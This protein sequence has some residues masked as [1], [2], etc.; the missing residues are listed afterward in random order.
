MVENL[1]V[2]SW[3]RLLLCDLAA[4]PA[5]RPL[6]LSVPDALF[7]Q[8]LWRERVCTFAF[9]ALHV[10]A[11]FVVRNSAAALYAAGCTAGGVCVCVCVCVCV[12]CV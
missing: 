4:D 10:P 6:I 9:E 8:P 3:E 2:S 12:W 7:E 11:F 5:S 1:L